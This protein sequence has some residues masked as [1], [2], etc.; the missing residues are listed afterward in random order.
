[1]TFAEL[2]AQI[3]EQD[4]QADRLKEIL[5][6]RLLALQATGAPG[7]RRGGRPGA[8]RLRAGAGGRRAEPRIARRAAAPGRPAHVADRAARR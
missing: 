5:R 7:G 1:M 3:R 4:A 6:E 8:R 2:A